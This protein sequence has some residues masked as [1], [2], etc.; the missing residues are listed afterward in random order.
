MRN[1]PLDYQTQ[2]YK[3]LYSRNQNTFINMFI[4]RR[5]VSFPSQRSFLLNYSV[6]GIVSAHGYNF[7][8]GICKG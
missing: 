7:S 5:L 4:K 1:I 6:Y 2:R 8:T 3:R